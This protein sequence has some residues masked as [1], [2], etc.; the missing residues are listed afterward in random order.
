M[1]YLMGWIKFLS[2]KL[3]YRLELESVHLATNSCLVWSL[4]NIKKR[5]SKF[6]HIN[7]SSPIINTVKII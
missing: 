6:I 1:G 4:R 3:L 7:T 5:G 2:I